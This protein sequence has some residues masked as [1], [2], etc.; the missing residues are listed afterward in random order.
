MQDH[1]IGGL[2]LRSSL[3][4]LLGAVSLVL[5]IACANVANLLLARA[6]G[7][8]KEMAIRSAVG[9]GRGRLVRQLLTESVLLAMAGGGLGLALGACGVRCLAAR[10]PANLLFVQ[11]LTGAPA[12][13]PRVTGFVVALAVIT[14][15]LFGLFPA[16]QIARTDL[17]CSLKESS[18]GTDTDRDHYSARD[19]LVV[20]EIAVAV[21]LVCGAMLLIRSFIALQRANTGF[22][23]RNLLTMRVALAGPEYTN[24]TVVSRLARQIEGRVDRIPGVEAAAMGSSLPYGPISDMIFDIPGRPPTKGYKFTGDVLWCFV[25]PQYFKTLKMPLMLGRSFREHEPAH[26]VIINE[27]M[28]RKF[29]PKENPVG[30]SIVIGAGLGPALDQGPT[31]IVGVVGKVPAWTWN[32]G[33]API[34]YQLWSQIPAG[35]LKVWSGLFPAAIAVRTKPGVAP[36]SV[37][38]AVQRALRSGGFDLAAA[39]IQTMEQAR[40][41]STPQMNLDGVLLG[42]FAAFAL[43]LAAVGLFGVISYTVQQRTREIGIRMALGAQSEDV[44][45]LIVGQGMRLALAGVCIGIVGAL[46]LT[47]FLRSLLYGVKPTDPLTFAAVSLIPASVAFLACCIPARRAT[48][49]DPMVALRYE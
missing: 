3:L 10:T 43:L 1:I 18:P 20:G 26:T 30:R 19:I 25:S 38:R 41:D 29:W 15:V 24:A 9:A 28:A 7:R 17:A 32:G 8:Q 21:V 42:A 49:V 46:G 14:G 37:S 2:R 6:L 33:T 34:M 11:D 39:Q 12:V 44:F 13:D 45:K 4:I 27:A 47:R 22:D 23:P 31:E 40:L 16:L 5:L 35:G 48:K 36:M